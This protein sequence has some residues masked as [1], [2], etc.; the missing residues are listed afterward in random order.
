MKIDINIEDENQKRKIDSKNQKVVRKTQDEKKI[1]EK[2]SDNEH[3]FESEKKVEQPVTDDKAVSEFR[4]DPVT[5][6]W[7]IIATGRAKRPDEFV[8][9]E[10]KKK[11]KSLREDCPFCGSN[12]DKQRPDTLI[13]Y[14][15]GDEWSLKVFPNLYPA[16]SRSKEVEYKEDD[17]YFL[18]DGE[19]GR[20]HV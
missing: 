15:E 8:S 9:K 12:I 5:S 13:Y 16:L 6:D 2:Q 7:V 14:R 20:A 18:M 11:V 19:I 17:M 3:I 10:E 1:K 4:Q